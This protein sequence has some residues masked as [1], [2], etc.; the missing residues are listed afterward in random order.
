[1]SNQSIP[2]PTLDYER[3]LLAQ[4]FQII[5]GVDEAGRGSIFGPVCVG[6]A[7]LPLDDL[8]ILAEKLSD[9]RDS[10]K[11]YRPKVYRLAPIIQQIALAWGVG[12][13][14]AKEIDKPEIGIMGA[15]QLAAGRALTQA[16]QQLG[17][18]VQY[19]L[20]D[21]A[22]RLPQDFPKD[23]RQSILK[24]DMYCLSIAC[25][26]ILAKHYHDEVVRNLAENYPDDYQLNRNVGYA[27]AAHINAVKQLG[28][29]PHHRHSFRPIAQPSL[30]DKN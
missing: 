29:T 3:E 10:K 15:I 16:E 17:G 6:I 24:G 2:V 25:G 21:T 14:T 12:Q 5:G 1:M 20:T 22:L 27:T 28:A 11:L 19:L 30:F 23:R 18:K 8:D 9:V 26:A 13:G 4:G 7:V